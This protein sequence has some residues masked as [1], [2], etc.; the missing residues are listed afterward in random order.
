MNDPEVRIFAQVSDQLNALAGFFIQKA[1]EAITQNGCF[2]VALSG[3]HSPRKLYELLATAYHKQVD[4]SKVY[5]FF[6]DERYVP[7][8]DS[9]SNAL[10]VRQ[11]LFDPLKIAGCNIF[12]VP[13]FLPPEEAA[14]SYWK[15]LQ[16]HF[17]E[18]PVRFDLI[19]LGL[20]D[21]AHTASLFPFSEVLKERTAG[22]KAVFIKELN[23]Y[24]ITFTAP[25]INQARH[26]AFLIYGASKSE[27]VKHVFK[28][29]LQP[30]KYP[31]QLIHPDPGTLNWFLDEAAAAQLK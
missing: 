3:G 23:A 4:W 17:K 13:T 10:M 6:G 15:L 14:I 30:E 21:N 28:A 12:I 26:I 18:Q 2:S 24:R 1:N 8:T 20:G 19:L 25:L 9:N 27:A 31:A 11:T 29:P 16:G 22:V 7:S 5:F